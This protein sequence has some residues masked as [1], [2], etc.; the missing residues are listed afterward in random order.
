MSSGFFWPFIF[1]CKSIHFQKD[2]VGE[3]VCSGILKAQKELTLKDNIEEF[4]YISKI[5]C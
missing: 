4:N 5:T 3:Y 1:S 2:N